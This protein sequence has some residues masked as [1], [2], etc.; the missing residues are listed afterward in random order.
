MYAVIRTGGKQ[1][2]VERGQQLDVER[3]GAGA[4]SDI[5]LTPVLVVDGDRVLATPAQLGEA[6]VRARI[7]DSVRAP[8]IVGF[9]YKSKSNQRKRWGHRQ[10]QS[11][12][13]IT[14]ISPGGAP[15]KD[16]AAEKAPAKKT[17][18]KKSPAKKTTAKK[19]PA[20]KSPA[21]KSPAKKSPA[22]KGTG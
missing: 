13:E 3:L 10:E 12:I 21:K 9:T 22:K 17:T 20:K 15:R 2:R 19:S 8:K 11:R 6:T 4:G 5:D 18:A 16:P 14:A 7:V 1:Y